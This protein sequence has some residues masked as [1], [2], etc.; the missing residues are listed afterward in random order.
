MTANEIMNEIII[1]GYE[2]DILRLLALHITEKQ[3]A[4]DNQ[5]HHYKASIRA[6][7][8]INKGKDKDIDSLCEVDD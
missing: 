7:Q 4:L 6:I 1:N 8:K 3:I 5:N 2:Y